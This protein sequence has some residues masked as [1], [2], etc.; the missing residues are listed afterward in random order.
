MFA[1]LVLFSVIN[2]DRKTILQRIGFTAIGTVRHHEKLTVCPYFLLFLFKY[3]SC[4]ISSFYFFHFISEN[5][6]YLLIIGVCACKMH[7]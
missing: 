6:Y 7:V 3:N 2:A 5:Y 1:I 4:F